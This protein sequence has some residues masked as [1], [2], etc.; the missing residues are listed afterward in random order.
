MRLDG[1][2]PTPTDLDTVAVVLAGGTGSRL[3]LDIPKQLLKIAG[4]TVLEHTV[5]II[6][7]APDVS[8]ILV[9]MTP[10]YEDEARE[11][12]GRF[13][14]VT[15]VLTGGETRAATTRIALDAID[16]TECNVLFH[17][18]V[19]PLLSH[20][21]IRECVNALRTDEAV[22]V[23]IPSPDTIIAVDG[24]DAINAIPPR[25]TL[26][27]GQ[28]PQGFLLST[29]RRA[30]A[31]AATDP[32]FVAT[33]D[34]GVV[35]RYL[36]DVPIR[37]IEGSTDNMKITLPV[38][39]FLVDK[40]FQ[41]STQVAPASIS[42]A[43]YAEELRGRTVV[44]FG[45]GSG[46]GADLVDLARE[47]GSD[48][49]SFSRT[50]T[51]THVED[52]AHVRAALADVYA[53]TGRIDH[54]VLTAGVLLTG[55]LANADAASVEESIGINFLAPVNVAQASVEYLARTKGQ[56]LLYTSSSYT[57]GRANYALYSACK[58]AVVNL[59]Q[60]LADEW[61]PLGIRVNCMN[62]ERTG[63]P[64]R[65]RAFGEEPPESLL[66]SIAVA[67]ASLDVLVSNLTG[68]VFDVRRQEASQTVLAHA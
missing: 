22:D 33:D 36:P 53:R 8:E 65:T 14:K 49:F 19:R 43:G 11:L 29:I 61:S 67:R 26:R 37:V 7:A 62:P 34:C 30:Y 68:H 39:L 46:I 50:E 4:R 54:V 63:T 6:D 12:L 15:A 20:R 51:G 32:D 45:G 28:T 40:L 16:R 25:A 57:R 3:G 44:V 41:L 48:V 2:K 5:A 66:A 27:L 64:M 59:M 60:A 35:H 42:D 1:A 23:A 31:L 9:M 17:D 21:I 38:D 24:D 10:G 13:P 18:A 47:Y 58:A 55:P 52:P 56:L